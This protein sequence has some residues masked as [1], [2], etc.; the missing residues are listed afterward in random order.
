[1]L[2]RE[3]TISKRL[4]LLLLLF[5]QCHITSTAEI[6]SEAARIRTDIIIKN[7]KNANNLTALFL[8]PSGC[9]TSGEQT[10]EFMLYS[11]QQLSGMFDPQK[12]GP[13]EPQQ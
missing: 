12:L 2:Q 5:V 4:F 10:E 6:T 8:H 9:A 7:M 3:Y 13:S 1:M 11:L